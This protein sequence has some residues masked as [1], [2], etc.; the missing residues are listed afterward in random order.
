MLNTLNVLNA[1][2]HSPYPHKM[3]YPVMPGTPKKQRK[4]IAQ[5]AKNLSSSGVPDTVAY[6]T[7]G[8]VLSVAAPLKK[9]GYREKD[10]QAAFDPP[11]QPITFGHMRFQ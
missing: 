5:L 7:E 10:L 4:L 6:V 2:Y 8:E 11:D 1:T 3:D 9:L